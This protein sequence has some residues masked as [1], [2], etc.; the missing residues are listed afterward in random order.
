MLTF[1]TIDFQG[2]IKALKGI[3]YND[4]VTFEVFSHD[5]D[6]LKISKEK[7]VAMFAAL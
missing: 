4:T 2:I 3:S 6:Y 1:G 5:R 7:F